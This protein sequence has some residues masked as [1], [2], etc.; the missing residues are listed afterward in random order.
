MPD[1]VSVM[2]LP[3]KLAGPLFTLNATGR[4]ELEVGTVTANGPAPK[5]LS[6]IAPNAA[7][8][9]LLLETLKLVVTSLAAL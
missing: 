1:P 8:V 2:V 7:I 6:L 4:L 9:W 3:F 5:T